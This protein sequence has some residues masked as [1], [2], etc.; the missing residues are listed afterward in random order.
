MSAKTVC[1]YRSSVGGTKHCQDELYSDGYCR[2]HF[3]CVQRGE[4]LPNGQINESLSDQN[5]RR[6]IN[7]HGQRPDD[8]VYREP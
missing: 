6:T 5:R 7:N 2:F 4:L 1:R 8:R 3:E